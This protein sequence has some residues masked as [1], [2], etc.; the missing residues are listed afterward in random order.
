LGDALKQEEACEREADRRYWEPLRQELG[1]LRRE[2]RP[3]LGD[4]P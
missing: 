3:S 4:L 1:R 2:Q